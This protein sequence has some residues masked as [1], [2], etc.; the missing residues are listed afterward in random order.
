MMYS[1][2]P[3][4]P[5]ATPL[6]AVTMMHSLSFLRFSSARCS[7]LVMFVCNGL[8]VKVLQI[9]LTSWYRPLQSPLLSSLVWRAATVVVEIYSLIWMS[10]GVTANVLFF[11]SEDFSSGVSSFL[12]R[13]NT[14]FPWILE[15]AEEVGVVQKVLIV[16]EAI[17][18]V[19]VEALKIRCLSFLNWGISYIRNVFSLLMKMVI[20]TFMKVRSSGSCC[21]DV[22]L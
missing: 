4:Q 16:L 18:E 17:L 9:V 13:L 21:R 7:A 19:V 15:I 5:G 22:L 3:L 14:H 12:E 8:L 2:C 20:C 10:A 1:F 6:S 11:C